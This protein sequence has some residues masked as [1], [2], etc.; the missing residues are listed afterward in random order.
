MAMQNKKYQYIDLTYLELMTEGDTEMQGTI[1][2]M[3]MEELPVELS[4][5]QA[6]AATADWVN[7]KNISHKLK[8]TLAFVGNAEVAG[9]NEQLEQ[10]L[11]EGLGKLAVEPLLNVLAERFPLIV[12][13]LKEA[14]N[15]ILA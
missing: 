2:Q 10:S 15:D 8:S 3:L 14:R 11:K 5:L 7:M 6:G 12:F 13:E 9:V 4:S 1:L